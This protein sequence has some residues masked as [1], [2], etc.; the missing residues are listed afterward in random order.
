MGLTARRQSHRL[1]HG[2][3]L[4]TPLL[5]NS[6]EW[7]VDIM[8]LGIAQSGRNLIVWKEHFISMNLISAL[9]GEQVPSG[10]TSKECVAY[11]C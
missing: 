11:K 4:L 1:H 8:Y 5:V 10:G 6:T 9:F 3:G 2:A 7:L